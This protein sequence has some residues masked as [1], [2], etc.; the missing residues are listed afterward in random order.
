MSRRS[1]ICPFL[2]ICVEGRG[3]RGCFELSAL[4]DQIA[5]KEIQAGGVCQVGRDVRVDYRRIYCM[6]GFLEIHHGVY[7]SS[8]S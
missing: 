3:D 5:S 4:R 8:K 7:T 6:Q 2:D 1:E